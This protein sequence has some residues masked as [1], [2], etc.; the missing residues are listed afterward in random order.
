MPRDGSSS[1]DSSLLEATPQKPPL[2]RMGNARE[3]PA[4]SDAMAATSSGGV[5]V[6]VRAGSLHAAGRYLSSL[7]KGFLRRLIAMR[8]RFVALLLVMPFM[9]AIACEYFHAML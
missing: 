4:N 5:S 8:S 3:S 9:I 7:V 1:D 2:P 6:P